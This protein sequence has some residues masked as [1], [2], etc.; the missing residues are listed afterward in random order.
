M[1]METGI[2]TRHLYLN[3]FV[4]LSNLNLFTTNH[5]DNIDHDLTEKISKIPNIFIT[6]DVSADYHL[7]HIYGNLSFQFILMI[8]IIQ[9]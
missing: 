8:T 6:P 7:Q 1:S 2:L 4:I 5:V 3:I 9:W